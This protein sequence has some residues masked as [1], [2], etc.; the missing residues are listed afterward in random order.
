MIL[1]R[2]KGRP[3]L[4]W[5][6]LYNKAL[7]GKVKKTVEVTRQINFFQSSSC[8]SLV[9]D[10]ECPSQIKKK[11]MATLLLNTKINYDNTFWWFYSINR[12][13]L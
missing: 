6:T 4:S 12:I 9:T 7:L 11:I 1:S 2:F 8:C 13:R 5:P 10:K 3:Q